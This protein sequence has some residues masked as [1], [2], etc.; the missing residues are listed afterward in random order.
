[1]PSISDVLT[2]YLARLDGTSICRLETYHDTLG[3]KGT[4]NPIAAYGAQPGCFASGCFQ[5][6]SEASPSYIMADGCWTESQL[7]IGYSYAVR[8][9]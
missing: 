6:N 1:M 8:A 3:L 7:R 4:I 5:N 2:S 9:E